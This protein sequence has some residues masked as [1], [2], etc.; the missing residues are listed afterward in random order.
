[1]GTRGSALALAQSRQVARELERLHH[2]LEVR[3]RI[4]RTTGDKNQTSSLPTIGGK[5]VFTLEIEAA[6][7]DG[8][9][10]FA[11]HSL[12]DLPPDLPDGLTLGCIPK[13][14]SA[15]DVLVLHDKH[16]SRNAI[17]YEGIFD[18][19]GVIIG[20]SS[21]R[22]RAMI[23]NMWPTVVVRDIRGN[24]DTRLKKLEDNFD[25]IILA[26]AGL[27]RL[28]IETHHTIHPLGGVGFVSAPGQG[29]LAIEC[30]ANDHRVLDLLSALEDS[31]TRM[32]IVAE[33]ACMRSLN[34][35]CSTPLGAHA[36]SF[37][38]GK[39]Y[40]EAV[41]LSADGAQR[42]HASAKNS[43]ENATLLGENVA[44]QLLEKGAQ[45]LLST[46]S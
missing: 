32:E 9:I 11:V 22:R 29:A 25:A 30:R 20:T 39:L 16:T 23:L 34:A 33:R 31:A 10:D 26:E 44:Q 42:I 28:K 24:I 3:E 12:K 6:L 38:Y 36:T 40:L 4:I 37:D 41:V 19:R 13:R 45:Q 15:D 18:T 7:L 5:G 14:E 27:K 8:T 43:P 1:M 21:L 46:S 17:V 2:G 35:G